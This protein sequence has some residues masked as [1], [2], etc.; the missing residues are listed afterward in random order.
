MTWN[1][2]G[3]VSCVHKM[4][5]S[6]EKCLTV[7]ISIV[8]CHHFKTL[9]VAC[10]F[11][12]GTSAAELDFHT[13]SSVTRWWT[14]SI[15]AQTQTKCASVYVGTL[16]EN[17]CHHFS[18]VVASTVAWQLCQGNRK[19][20]PLMTSQ[21]AACCWRLKRGFVRDRQT[22]SW[23]LKTMSYFGRWQEEEAV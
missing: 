19:V 3:T 18:C 23:E 20:Y 7:I 8:H 11:E 14:G 17:K 10:S 21:R 5:S 1:S 9:W 13:H 6:C 2:L 22:A 15:P 12:N 16:N 4:E